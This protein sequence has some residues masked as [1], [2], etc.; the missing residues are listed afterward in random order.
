MPP[1]HVIFKNREFQGL[2]AFPCPALHSLLLGSEKEGSDLKIPLSAQQM[3]IFPKVKLISTIRKL[4]VLAYLPGSIQRSLKQRVI[5]VLKWKR[6]QN[7]T[8]SRGKRKKENLHRLHGDVRTREI[9][10]KLSP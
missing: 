8:F 9:E 10:E 7:E 4:L 3:E 1:K 2:I 5:Q 6:H